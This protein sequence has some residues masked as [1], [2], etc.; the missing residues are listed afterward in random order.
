MVDFDDMPDWVSS[1]YDELVY[2]F[3]DKHHP[4]LTIEECYVRVE[5]NPADKELF[6]KLC[7][8]KFESYMQ[9][10]LVTE[11]DG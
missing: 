7:L 6:D 8:S 2:D 10:T 4:G 1:H 3:N 9:G 5:K 11:N